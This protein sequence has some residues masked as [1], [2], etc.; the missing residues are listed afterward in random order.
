MLMKPV[1]GSAS[2]PFIK[3]CVCVF[4]CVHVRVHVK[5]DSGALARLSRTVPEQG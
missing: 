2:R 3:L 1:L 5:G 4:A